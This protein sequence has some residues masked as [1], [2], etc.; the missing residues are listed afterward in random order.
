MGRSVDVVW[1]VL[2][3]PVSAL[4]GLACGHVAAHAIGVD[5]DGAGVAG[6]MLFVGLPPATI[7]LRA[8]AHRRTFG[9]TCVL[10]CVT[11]VS[12]AATLAA[13]VIALA[14]AYARVMS[15]F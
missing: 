6:V 4:L 2:L 9:W 12:T 7:F 14:I 15:G 5:P 3:G 1:A 10:L 13:L 11:L 8:R